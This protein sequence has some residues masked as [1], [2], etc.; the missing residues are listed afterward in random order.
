MLNYLQFLR[1]L[2]GKQ[3]S[4]RLIAASQGDGKSTIQRFLK[5]FKECEKFSFPLL[6]TVINEV[7]YNT[8]YNSR[9]GTNN[10]GNTH[11]RAVDCHIIYKALPNKA[12]QLHCLLR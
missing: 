6:S 2:F 8:L 11:Y 12:G 10:T 1:F 4:G 3:M 7:I 9:R 5:K